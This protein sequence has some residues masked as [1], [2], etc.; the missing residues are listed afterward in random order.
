LSF[1]FIIII[2][3]YSKWVFFSTSIKKSGKSKSSPDTKKNRSGAL[4]G[5][6]YFV[7][8]RICPLFDENNGHPEEGRLHLSRYRAKT[9]KNKTSSRGVT[10][11]FFYFLH[12]FFF[13]LHYTIH[14][15]DAIN[16]RNNQNL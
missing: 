6:D 1:L 8:R 16:Y 2:L 9:L 15:P 4:M 7:R 10:G 5:Y 11:N 3:F 12:P 14:E 13:H